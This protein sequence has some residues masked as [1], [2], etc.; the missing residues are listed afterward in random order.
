LSS[1]RR[2]AIIHIGTGKTGSTTIQN[3]LASNRERLLEQGFAYPESPGRRNHLRLAVFA[4]EDRRAAKLLRISSEA[5]SPDFLRGRLVEQLG[6]EIAALPASV[7]TV[8]F[9]NEHLSR[10]VAT[11]EDAARLKA[12][13]DTWFDAYRILVYLRRQDEYAVSLYST[14]LRA[15]RTDADVLAVGPEAD[16]RLDWAALLD[17]WGAVFGHDA[18]L[19]RVFD[20]GSFVNGDLLADMRAACGLA[21]LPVPDAADL[22]NPSLTAPAQEFLRRLNLAARGA[23]EPDE[24]DEL[25]DVDEDETGEAERD[26]VEEAGKAPTFIR[27]FL[28]TRFAGP[29]LRPSRAAAEAF[30]AHYAAANERV[31]EDFFPARTSLFS[32]DF[33]RYPEAA[34]P[35]PGPGQLLDVAIAVVLA[36]N[37]EHATMLADGA[38][39]RGRERL[40]AG[41]PE[42]ARR[43]FRRAL[44]KQP[45]HVG[46]LRGLI[47]L[48]N[49]PAVRDE[50]ANRLERALGLEPERQELATLRQ[51]LARMQAAA[52]TP[53]PRVADAD[54]APRRRSAPG[55]GLD[56]SRRRADSSEEGSSTGRAPAR[57]Q[58][59]AAIGAPR[60]RLATR[61]PE[62]ASAPQ[63]EGQPEA[64]PALSPEQRAE[65]RRR[66]AE[67]LRQ[68]Q[69]AD[70]QESAAD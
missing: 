34:D 64:R 23:G 26:A 60:R 14:L 21:P 22:L 25:H 17:R 15:G 36:Q 7:R 70:A 2:R 13:L 65:R 45:T 58:D 62:D 19:P 63:G 38:A 66:R 41:E 16:P 37:A 57:I 5:G 10:Q 68:R 1:Q 35:P 54:G 31:R 69:R 49:D 47:E 46:A 12:L 11:E 59:S 32:T 29:G 55:M 40:A 9:S 3:L 44:G 53:K 56:A 6:A 43:L 27:Q 48:A 4:S 52:E 8:I 33:S 30:V 20:R 67:R 42:E 39:R 24:E 18:L 51:R 28:S 50:A 61:Q